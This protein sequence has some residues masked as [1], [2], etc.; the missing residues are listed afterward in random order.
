MIIRQS[1]TKYWLP[2]STTKEHSSLKVIFFEVSVRK[3]QFKFQNTVSLSGIF[4]Q[5]QRMDRQLLCHGVFVVF[6]TKCELKCQFSGNIA[7]ICFHY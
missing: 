2:T 7:C 5:R 6:K 1:D 4:L 3:N